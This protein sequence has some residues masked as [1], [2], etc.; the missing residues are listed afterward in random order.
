MTQEEHGRIQ[1]EDRLFLAEY[2]VQHAMRS[3][4]QEPETEPL[5]MTILQEA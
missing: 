3:Q 4:E 2:E 5:P 1:E